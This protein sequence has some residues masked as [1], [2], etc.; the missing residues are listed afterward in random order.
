VLVQYLLVLW[1]TG[2]PADASFHIP[3]NILCRPVLSS[4]LLAAVLHKQ[5]VL[6]WHRSYV[7]YLISLLALSVRTHYM[8]RLYPSLSLL[9]P[10]QYDV[11]IP[12]QPQF[13]LVP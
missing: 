11:H 1:A 13:L 2:N 7:Q 4:I 9:S 12:Y 6:A 3:L 8:H 10:Q 5:A